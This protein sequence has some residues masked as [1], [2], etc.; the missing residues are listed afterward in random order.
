MEIV[1]SFSVV[2]AHILELII[3][4]KPTKS[5]TTNVRQLSTSS[6]IRHALAPL[7][8]VDEGD[9]ISQCYKDKSL[10]LPLETYV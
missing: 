10:M 5:T 3:K 7:T 1:S 6:S 8:M 4:L 9:I 2:N